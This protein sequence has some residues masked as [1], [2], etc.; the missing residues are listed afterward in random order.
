MSYQVRSVVTGHTVD[1]RSAVLFD[2]KIQRT[3][4]CLRGALDDPTRRMV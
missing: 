2:S 1:G 4:L 3:R